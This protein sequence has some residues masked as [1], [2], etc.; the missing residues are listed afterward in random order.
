MDKK[1]VTFMYLA[2]RDLAPLGE[3]YKIVQDVETLVESGEEIKMTN[4]YMKAVAEEIVN[5]IYN[6]QKI[7]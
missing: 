7:R 5:R 6:G 4:K 3:I 2:I 1:L